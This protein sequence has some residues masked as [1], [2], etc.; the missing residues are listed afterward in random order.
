M[1]YLGVLE[2]IRARLEGN[3]PFFVPKLLENSKWDHEL[4]DRIIGNNAKVKI[5]GFPATSIN[6]TVANFEVPVLFF[7]AQGHDFTT[8]YPSFTYEV[9]DFQPRTA[10]GESW[11]D[12]PAYQGESYY[13]P[14]PSAFENNVTDSLGNNLGT[15]FRM[16]RT[17]P[18]ERPFDIFVEIRAYSEDPV[19]SALMVKWI[20]EHFAPTFEFLRVP[21][22]DGTYRSWDMFQEA[23]R[24]LDKRDAARAG[25]PGVLR[26]Y[27]KVWTFRVE[28]YLD[29]T[30]QARLQ[31]FVRY[32][33]ARVSPM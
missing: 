1:A 5:E 32:V 21:M 28:G 31:N 27:A 18:L 33:T 15:V 23:F 6:E 9:I 11:W 26:E 17:R 8:Q 7:D 24:D 2:A 3:H 19:Q 10:E 22:L 4:P 16:A 20:T 30:D 14:V 29:N 25:S 12:S 13:N